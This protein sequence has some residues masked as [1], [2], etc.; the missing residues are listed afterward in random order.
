LHSPDTI[1]WAALKYAQITKTKIIATHHTAFDLYLPY[2]HLQWTSPLVWFLIRRLYNKLTLVTAPSLVIADELKKHGVTNAQN[3]PWGADL[4]V[5]NPENYSTAWRKE[6]CGEKD[7]P[8]ISFVSRLVWEKDLRTLAAT[9]NLLRKKLG[10]NGFKMFV[11][12]HG[13]ASVELKK[14]MPGAIFKD[15]LEGNELPT[16]YASSDIFLFPST[17]ETFGLVV[18][19]AMACG[20]VPVVA[21]SGGD[22]SIIE[23]NK[24]GLLAQAKN[25]QSFYEK[26]LYLIE[27]PEILKR[28]HD[29]GLN[30]AKDYDWEKIL[31]NFFNLYKK[32]IGG[33]VEKSDEL[34]KVNQ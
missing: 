7:Q 32:T 13:P 24:N 8:I 22:M 14:L 33:D 5:F 30:Y 2:Y 3:F 18:L 27:H 23:D 12:G 15:H 25:P 19:E 21:N 29:Y 31:A 16:A 34:L 26:T 9:Y 6:I 20:A 10:P 28:L 4:H 17:T 1:A 11:S